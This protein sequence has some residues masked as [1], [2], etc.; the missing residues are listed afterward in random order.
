MTPPV[1][2]VSKG[3]VSH[4]VFREKYKT[5]NVVVKTGNG[6]QY[7][8]HGTEWESVKVGDELKSASNN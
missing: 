8:F 7:T 1:V 2:V 6:K 4:G 5:F 3:T